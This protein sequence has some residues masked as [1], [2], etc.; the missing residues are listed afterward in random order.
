MKKESET[1]NFDQA[2]AALGVTRPGLYKMIRNGTA[3][4]WFRFHERYI[5]YKESVDK[6]KRERDK[7]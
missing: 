5:F 7:K 4:K 3:P 2:A 6:L 1:Y